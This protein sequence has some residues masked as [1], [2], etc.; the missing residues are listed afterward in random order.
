[1]NGEE[2]EVSPR[3]LARIGGVLYLLVIIGGLYGEVFLRGKLIVPGDAT[4]T[5]T[6]IRSME[7]LWRTGVAIE[8]LILISALV[9]FW[10]LFILLR[11]VS[12]DLALLAL[13][14]NLVSLSLEANNELR[15]MSALFPLGGAGYLEAFPPEQLHAMVSLTLRS[16]SHGFGHGLIFFGA[17]LLVFGYLI[18]RST[19][20]PK[21][22]GVL[23]QIAGVCYLVNSFALILSPALASRLFPGI[24]LPALVGELSLGLWLLFKGIDLQRW[25]A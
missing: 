15:L 7:T 13:L 2:K 14:F 8:V 19:Y 5:A 18:F 17:A 9:L 3:T 1:M 16:Y 24:L 11:P 12:G 23:V 6:G 20:L 21:P 4:A 22:V 25:K 10:I